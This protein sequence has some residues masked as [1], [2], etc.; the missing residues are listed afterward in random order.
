MSSRMRLR[1]SEYLYICIVP[2]FVLTR[3]EYERNFLILN[4]FFTKEM[5]LLPRF[6]FLNYSCEHKAR[7]NTLQTNFIFE[8]NLG[9][10]DPQIK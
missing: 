9:F 10:N 5:S 8:K 2:G 6:Y 4:E 7:K 3:N 1:I